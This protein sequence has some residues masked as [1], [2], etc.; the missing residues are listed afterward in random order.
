LFQSSYLKQARLLYQ[1]VQKFVHYKRDMLKPDKLAEIERLRDQFG[2]AIKAKDRA[3]IEELAAQLTAVCDKAVAA[4]SDAG[5]RDWVES[6]VTCAVIVF[7]IRAYFIQP[8][9]IPTGSMQPTLNGIIPNRT[10]ADTPKPNILVQA[11]ELVT[12]G[13]NY[14]RV[15]APCDGHLTKIEQKSIGLFVTTSTLTFTDPAGSVHKS[16]TWAPTAQLVGTADPVG[17]AIDLKNSGLWLDRDP[18]NRGNLAVTN[19]SG[20][21]FMSAPIPVRKGQ[22]LAAGSV[23]SGD[24]VLV[25]KISYHFRRPKRGEVFV[26]TTRNIRGIEVDANEGSQ[27]YIKRLVGIPGDILSVPKPGGPLLVNGAP[28]TEEGIRRVYENPVPPEQPGYHGYSNGGSRM[29]GPPWVAPKEPERSYFAMG[30]NSFNSY[31]SRYWHAVPEQ[32]LV[33]PGLF[34]LWPITTGHWGLIK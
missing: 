31:D 19:K 25:D 33:G 8:F 21:V 16:T 24:M 6:L 11:W 20:T 27:H 18:V 17:Q 29:I 7:A 26:F 2:A 14:V 13:R 30:D 28:A 5:T 9:K 34:S 22:V 23:D 10:S 3:R 1:G 4:P 15:V 32:N 12:R